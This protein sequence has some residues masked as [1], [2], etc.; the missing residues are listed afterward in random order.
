MVYL[1]TKF[2]VCLVFYRK[3]INKL[4]HKRPPGLVVFVVYKL[5]L[6]SLLTITAIFLF[7]AGNNTQ[8]LLSFLDSYMFSDF[9]SWEEKVEVFEQLLNKIISR[10]PKTLHVS[11]IIAGMYAVATAI[12]AIGLWYEKAWARILVLG[13]V[14]ISLP[15][16]VFEL[17]RGVTLIKLVVFLVNISIFWYLLRHF[18]KHRR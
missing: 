17:V 11:G 1:V 6:T 16:E 18:P 10:N 15:V 4:K 14:G 8:N 5:L 13:I 2:E 12:Q 7:L 9:V 3:F